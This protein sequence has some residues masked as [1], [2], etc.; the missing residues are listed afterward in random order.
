M[1]RMSGRWLGLA[2]TML[3][4]AATP[5]Q[6][7]PTV[8]A[9]VTLSKPGKGVATGPDGALWVAQAENPGRIARVSAG[10]QV[11]EYTGAL[12]AGFTKDRKPTGMAVGPDGALWFVEQVGN[13][14][15]G[16][17][18]TS[19]VVSEFG[20]LSGEPTDIA[21]GPDGDLWIT[22]KDADLPGQSSVG[23]VAKVS[24]AGAVLAQ[25]ATGAQNPTHIA[26]GRDGALWFSEPGAV[27]R[28]TVDGAVTKHATALTPLGLAG[29]SDDAVYAAA[30]T[31]IGR[32]TSAGFAA[33]PMPLLDSATA[34]AEGPDGALWFTAKDMIGRM[35]PDGAVTIH[36]APGYPATSIAAGPDGAMWFTPQDA[37]LG[38]ITVPPYLGEARAEQVEQTTAE[39]RAVVRA[40]SETTTA[41]L[42]LRGPGNQLVATQQVQV[43]PGAADVEVAFALSGLTE[44]TLYTARITA[45]NASGPALEPAFAAFQ[46]K[47]APAPTP[48]ATPT[49]TPTAEPTPTPTVEP[50]PTPTPTPTA[51]PT[52]GP[53]VDPVPVLRETVVL[54][55]NTGEVAVRTKGQ[56]AFVPLADVSA[57]P[58][59]ALVDTR[60]GEVRLDSALPGGSVQAGYFSGGLFRVRQAANGMTR[61]A[62]AGRLDCG[63]RRAFK[64]RKR[65]RR[66]WG[67]DSGGRFS[68]RGRDAVATVR[69]TRW[70]TIDTCRGTVVRVVEGAVAVRPL[71]G[72]PK[73]LVEA[74]E[75]HLVRRR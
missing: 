30:G 29:A 1:K 50:T 23:A 67:R 7:A 53:A 73:V 11:T 39:V 71:A 40:N 62:L 41:A 45:S 49:P 2:V 57:V 46:T 25:Y 17:I 4:L 63:T 13:G 65:K 35:R 33:L 52:P 56:P 12:T 27:G 43:A 42:Q 60:R 9:P 59:G 10:G 8:T 22:L 37:L 26:A 19:G 55:A 18:T 48:T 69:G 3:G 38:R 47:P 70:L 24:P 20:P 75:R 16:R 6:A 15:V 21:R 64:Q 72:G 66:V 32:V 68:T 61:L 44:A 34:I 74:G 36:S 5:A 58:V 28:V 54:R 51:E 31:T 14:Y